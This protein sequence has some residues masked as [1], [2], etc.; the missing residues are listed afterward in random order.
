MKASTVLC[1]TVLVAA[2]A[3]SPARAVQ[4]TGPVKLVDLPLKLPAVGNLDAVRQWRFGRLQQVETSAGPDIVLRIRTADN[5]VLRISGPRAELAELAWQS[6]W[7]STPSKSKP[8]RSDYVE[9]MIAFDVDA[10]GRL[11]AMM[12]L[13]P[14]RRD[15]S[16]MRRALAK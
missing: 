14:V 7:V 16:R 2:A 1:T 9:R 8:G 5:T 3:L 15:R 6:N 12:S 11:I 4:P 10:N 13:E